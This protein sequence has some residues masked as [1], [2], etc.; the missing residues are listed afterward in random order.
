MSIIAVKEATMAVHAFVNALNAHLFTTD[1]SRQGPGAGSLRRRAREQEKAKAEA[2]RWK[3]IGPKFEALR[4][5]KTRLVERQRVRN[6]LR[7]MK[8]AQIGTVTPRRR[9]RG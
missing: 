9:G 4:A 7:A 5:Q 3:E 6:E 2:K 1:G 8:T